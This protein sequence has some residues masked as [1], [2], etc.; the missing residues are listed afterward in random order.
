MAFDKNKEF[1]IR[2][3]LVQDNRSSYEMFVCKHTLMMLRISDIHSRD[4]PKPEEYGL[5]EYGHA[6]GNL[7][8]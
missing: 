4:A 7:A 1:W 3:F 5:A 6:K 8:L 2:M